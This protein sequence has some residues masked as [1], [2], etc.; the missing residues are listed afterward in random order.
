MVRNYISQIIINDN[1]GN[2][3]AP[4]N[5]NSLPPPAV[6]Q[7]QLPAPNQNFQPFNES[8]ENIN[9]QP[10]PA[11][12]T[13]S[14]RNAHRNRSRSVFSSEND[15]EVPPINGPSANRRFNNPNNNQQPIN[16]NNNRYGQ[17]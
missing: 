11:P 7:N 2:N 1:P 9:P 4:V 14:S 12:R 5:N 8:Q 15:E 6:P 10:I 13:S 3:Q 16:N 17:Q